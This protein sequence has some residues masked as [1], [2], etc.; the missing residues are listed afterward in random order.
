MLRFKQFQYE[1]DGKDL[2]LT[3]FKSS[4][5]W[6][7]FLERNLTM[8]GLTLR[9]FEMSVD[10]DDGWYDCFRNLLLSYIMQH[11]SIIYFKVKIRIG[12]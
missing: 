9:T 4:S 12:S 8:K 7:S 10:N 2:S 1:Y 11:F 6:L 5:K 3:S